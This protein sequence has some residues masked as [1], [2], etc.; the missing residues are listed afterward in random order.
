VIDYGIDERIS[1]G[2]SRGIQNREREKSGTI[3]K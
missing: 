3:S 2:K 1:M